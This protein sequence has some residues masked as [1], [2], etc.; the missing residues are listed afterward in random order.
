MSTLTKVLLGGGALLLVI[1]LVVYFLPT[2][3]VQTYASPGAQA[4]A[5]KIDIMERICLSSSSQDSSAG[6]SSQL[7]LVKTDLKSGADVTSQ[8]KRL[9]GVIEGLGGVAGAQDRSE[10][11]KCMVDMYA[12][13]GQ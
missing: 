10:T 12:K 5:D 2:H 8:K 1:A 6:V 11:R 4:M 7:E 13:M 3:T 9:L